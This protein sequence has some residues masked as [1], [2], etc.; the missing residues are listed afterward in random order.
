[1]QNNH[2]KQASQEGEIIKGKV[3][4]YLVVHLPATSPAQ[5]S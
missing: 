5:E 3:K 4:G 2:V 1:M